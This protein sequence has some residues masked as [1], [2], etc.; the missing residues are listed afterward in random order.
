LKVAATRTYSGCAALWPTLHNKPQHSPA[1]AF[2]AYAVW[3]ENLNCSSCTQS[4]YLRYFP[5][6]HFCF[7]SSCCRSLAYRE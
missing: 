6:C 3:A 1:S 4:S 5:T 2:F 7:C